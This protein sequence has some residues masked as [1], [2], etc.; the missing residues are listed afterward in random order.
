LGGTAVLVDKV[1]TGEATRDYYPYGPEAS[2]TGEITYGYTGKERDDESDL[3]YFGARYYDATLARWT[4]KDPKFLAAS[5]GDLNLYR[6]AANNPTTLVDPDG[7]EPVIHLAQ[8]TLTQYDGSLG[9]RRGSRFKTMV[10][11][12]SSQL[13]M[14]PGRLAGHALSEAL[15]DYYLTPNWVSSYSIGVDNYYEEKGE[16]ER[17]LPAASLPLDSKWAYAE[18]NDAR[19]PYYVMS[20]WFERGSDGLLAS[21]AQLLYRENLLRETASSMNERFDDFPR[22]IQWGLAELAFMAGNGYAERQLRKYI[23]HGRDPLRRFPQDRGPSYPL[24]EAA[25]RVAQMMH[26]SQELDLEQA[27]FP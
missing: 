4:S 21:G 3:H 5:D 24:R 23:E 7:R 25:I 8:E 1:G 17:L 18:L 12:V 10:Y 19:N 27:C 15:R 22:D 20:V 2:H 13:G 14:D 16:I 6:F 11:E 26:L 9:G